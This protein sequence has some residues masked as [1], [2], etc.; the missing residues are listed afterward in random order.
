MLDR[1]WTILDHCLIGKLVEMPQPFVCPLD[2]SYEIPGWVSAGLEWRE[3]S[4]FSNPLAPPQLLQQ[5]V[6]LRVG[7]GAA[8]AA[9]GGA[10][11]SQQQQRPP[12]RTFDVRGGATFAE[13]EAGAAAQDGGGGRPGPW[14]VCDREGRS[15]GRC[16]CRGRP[17]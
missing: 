6:G 10:A 5:A 14:L 3:H 4:F 12:S 13:A 1:F 15:V 9:G 7:G 17:T 16:R 2:H 11:A 8:A